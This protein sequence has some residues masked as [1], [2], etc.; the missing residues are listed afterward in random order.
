MFL[1]LE[2]VD[3]MR[4]MDPGAGTL[5]RPFLILCIRDAG[6]GPFNIYAPPESWLTSTWLPAPPTPSVKFLLLAIAAMVASMSW[7]SSMGLV[8]GTGRLLL[9]LRQP[10]CIQYSPVLSSTLAKYVSSSFFFCLF[11]TRP[12][13]NPLA[14]IAFSFLLGA[15]VVGSI[16]QQT[17]R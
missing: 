6:R 10:F 15:V 8:L 12:L 4:P 16:K 5:M 1:S 14:V 2:F 7:P 17:M 11:A 13:A 3:T 9:V